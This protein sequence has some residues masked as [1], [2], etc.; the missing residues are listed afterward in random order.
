MLNKLE[1]YLKPQNVE[2]AWNMYSNKEN[3]LFLTGGLSVSL[4]EDNSTN[5][6][7][8]LKNTLSK[9]ISYDSD[10]LTIGGGVSVNELIDKADDGLLKDSLKCIGS[11]QIRNMSSISGGIAQRYAW[12]DLISILLGFDTEVELYN[13]DYAL[14]PLEKYIEEK[15]VGI[16]CRIIIDNGFNYGKYFKFSRT[17]YDVSIFN[18]SI[19][20]KCDGVVLQANIICG[21]RPAI[22]KKLLESS[23]LLTGKKLPLTDSQ[24]EDLFEIAVKEAQLRGNADA[25]EEYRQKLLKSFLSKVLK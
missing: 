8:D 25:S 4:R 2:E 12:S 11:H 20:L 1:E 16:I 23:D 5:V 3:A 9:D 13:G 22:S 7:I 21:S 19:F 15:P 10:K 17:T 6:L 24:F 14:L 18:T